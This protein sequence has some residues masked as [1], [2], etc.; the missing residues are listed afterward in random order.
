M[1]KQWKTNLSPKKYIKL[2][3]RT[4]PLGKC[5]V[6]EN[7]KECGMANIIVTRK[8]PDGCL[9]FGFFLVDIWALGTKDCFANIHY[10]QST[11]EEQF[12]EAAKGDE[13][14]VE[15]PYVLAHNIIYGANAFAEECGF[16]LHED[17]KITQHIL[18]E[19]TEDI[20]L[21]ELE[22]GKDGEPFLVDTRGFGFDDF[23][24]EDFDEDDEE[25]FDD[26]DEVKG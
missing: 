22:F 1:E 5:Y 16:K 7:W 2:K 8:H 13:T 19:D 23:D 24:D 10:R 6:N 14:F 3:A 11:F 20:P 12:L 15:I 21:I 4:L 17:F 26:Y 18:M 25:E 9:T